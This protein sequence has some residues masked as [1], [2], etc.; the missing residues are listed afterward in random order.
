[1]LWSVTLA[2]HGAANNFASLGAL[3]FLLGIFEAAISPGFSLI[4]AMWYKPSEHASRHG[5]WFVGNATASLF[6]GVL[7]YA[8]GHIDSGIAA[9]RVRALVALFKRFLH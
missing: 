5:L 9:W 3:R 7:S 6:G 8:I 1:M 2:C 4:T